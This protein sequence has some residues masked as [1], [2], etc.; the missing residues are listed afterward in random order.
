MKTL[1]TD[2][3]IPAYRPGE[4]FE[5]LLERLSAQK[6]PINK[7]LVMNTEK[8]FWKE[9]WE[10]EYP[11]VE[12]RHLTKEEFDHGGTRRQAAELSDAEILVFMTQDAMPADR[13]LIGALVGA[14]AENPQAGAAYARQL[15]KKDCRFLEKYTRSFNYPEQSCLKT[16]KDVQTYGIKTYFCSNVCAAYDHRIYDEIGGFPEHA[17]FNEDMIY[18]GW[19]VKKGYGVAY[20]SEARVYHSHNYTCMQQF[21][22]NFDLGVSQKQYREVFESISSEKEGAGYAKTVLLYLLKRG[23]IWKAFYFAL[24]CGFKLAGYKLGKNYDR[25]PKGLVLACTMSPDYVLFHEDA[26]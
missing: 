13:E 5:K 12:V 25:L 16:E 7:I 8:K 19:M 10:Q 20:V 21:H 24:Q 23:R 9:T 17:I 11:L 14:L 18:A 3:I 6:Y 4:E 2:V 26:A 15:P 1:K 22:R